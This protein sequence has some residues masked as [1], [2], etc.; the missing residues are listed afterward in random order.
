MLKS[1]ADAKNL[2]GNDRYEG[3]C[4]DLTEKLSQLVNFTYE[5]RIVKDKTFGNKGKINF[6]LNNL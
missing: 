4:V 2:T 5:L 1:D 3:Y 6:F